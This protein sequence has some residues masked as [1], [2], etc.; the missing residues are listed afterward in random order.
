L[1]SLRNFYS[2]DL[3]NTMFSF[4]YVDLTLSG[5]NCERK[6]NAHVEKSRGDFYGT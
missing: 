5:M 6:K 1:V 3:E 2:L 4:E